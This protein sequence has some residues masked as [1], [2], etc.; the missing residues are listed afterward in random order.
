MGL[1][2][3]CCDYFHHL[4]LHCA[5][6]V[7]VL[8]FHISY[9]ADLIEDSL[10]T[11][12]LFGGDVGVFLDAQLGADGIALAAQLD[13]DGLFEGVVDTQCIKVGVDPSDYLP[14]LLDP[15]NLFL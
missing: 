9:V 6:A 5:L 8:V 11:I 3:L 10:H 4:I 14:V 12:K 7:A 15:G 13:I 2:L 1:E